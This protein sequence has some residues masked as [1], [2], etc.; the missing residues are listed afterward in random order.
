M[1]LNH[2]DKIKQQFTN[3]YDVVTDLILYFGA[4]I[5]SFS[6]YIY[7]CPWLHFTS[8]GYRGWGVFSNIIEITMGNKWTK[9]SPFYL[10]TRHEEGL[11]LEEVL[12]RCVLWSPWMPPFPCLSLEALPFSLALSLSRQQTPCPVAS[13]AGSPPASLQHMLQPWPH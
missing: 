6:V 13:T 5:V 7:I 10:L 8:H 3:T 2:C 12:D 9:A 1:Q 11:F 4:Y